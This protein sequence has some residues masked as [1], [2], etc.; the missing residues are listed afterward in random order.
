VIVRLPKTQQQ[1]PVVMRVTDDLQ[2]HFL[3]NDK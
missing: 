3:S 1:A 2:L